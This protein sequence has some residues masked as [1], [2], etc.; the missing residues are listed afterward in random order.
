MLDAELAV[1]HIVAPPDVLVQL[2]ERP[3]GPL[4]PSR[5]LVVLLT[6]YGAPVLEQSPERVLYPPVLE[7]DPVPPLHPVGLVLH[8]LEGAPPPLAEDHLGQLLP[9]DGTVILRAQHPEAGG[10]L[11]AHV[12][13]AAAHRPDGGAAQAHR[14]VVLAALGHQPLARR[15]RVRSLLLL[16]PTT[17]PSSSGLSLSLL[18]LLVS[19]PVPI[20]VAAV[21]KEI[22]TGS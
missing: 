22:K 18:L 6:A 13:V 19:R 12:V 14:A 16:L 5:T 20:F 8:L 15:R 1:K 10:A 4:V 9:A 11:G 21:L 3:E 17:S 7:A 2:P